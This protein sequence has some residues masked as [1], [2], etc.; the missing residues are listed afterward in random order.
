MFAQNVEENQRTARWLKEAQKGYIRVAVLILL[1]RKPAHGYEIMKE[2]KDRT[3][4]F[5][6]PTAGGVY[7]IL[8]D[9]EKA[10]YVEG[11][12]STQNNRKIKVYK[13]TETGRTILRNAIVKQNEIAN[14]MNTLFGEFARDVLNLEQTTLPFPIMPTP[15]SPFLEEKDRESED[16]TED[17][18]RKRIDL[19]RMIKMLQDELQTT[20]K[21]LAKA[22]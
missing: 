18:E 16:K 2:I 21:R 1:N 19:K 10:R 20:N 3:K 5:W 13:I 11:E 9:L 15:F 17:L 12:W 14:N 8:L 7:P 6:K 4:G 22:K